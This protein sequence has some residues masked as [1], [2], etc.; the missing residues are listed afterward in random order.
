MEALKLASGLANPGRSAENDVRDT[1]VAE[2]LPATLYILSDGKFPPVTGFLL[3][4]LD[5]KFIP[6]G[7]AE[8][9]NIA[10]LA[11]S[12]QR[13]ESR[14]D[15][16]QAF[17][18][19]E[20]FGQKKTKVAAELYLD[21]RLVDAD[22]VEVTPE[23]PRGIAFDI[24]AVESGVLRLKNQVERQLETRRR[25]YF[26]AANAAADESPAGYA[27]QRAAFDRPDHEI[28]PGNRRSANRTARFSEKQGRSTK[29]PAAAGAFDLVIYDRCHPE[30]MPQANTLFIADL[31]PGKSWTRRREGRC[32]A[33]YRHRFP[34]IPCC[35]GWICTM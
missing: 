8:S 2:A 27:R 11:F 17:A 9:K 35:N 3:G 25:G 16:F 10:I 33:D 6:V 4:N 5:P 12:A 28:G 24:A 1:Q 19:V 13:N 18:R 15:R 30:Q 22:E 7:L 23:E 29:R 14:P 32:A 26:G 31:P 34:P 21:D 20:S